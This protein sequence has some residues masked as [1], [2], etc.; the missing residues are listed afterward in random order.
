MFKVFFLVC[1]STEVL[2]KY[3]RSQNYPRMVHFRTILSSKVFLFFFFFF[4]CNTV[5]KVKFDIFSLSY[6][7]TGKPASYVTYVMFYD[8]LV[9]FFCSFVRCPVYT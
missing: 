2:Q 5:C 1:I 8:I 4:F 3:L 9:G 6:M 7:H